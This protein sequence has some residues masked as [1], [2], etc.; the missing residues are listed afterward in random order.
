MSQAFSSAL[1]IYLYK[2]HFWRVSHPF[3]IL[4]FVVP[5]FLMSIVAMCYSLL[6]I[7]MLCCGYCAFVW[8]RQCVIYPAING[9]CH[10]LSKIWVGCH[11]VAVCRPTWC[12][13]SCF[14]HRIVHGRIYYC[15]S[16]VSPVT[17]HALVLLIFV[18]DYVCRISSSVLAAL[19]FLTP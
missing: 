8:A 19:S 11:F 7:L 9:V 3:A 5:R 14:I 16:F 13:K 10:I 2:K 17:S 1:D 6:T 4:K 12:L 15:H 18:W